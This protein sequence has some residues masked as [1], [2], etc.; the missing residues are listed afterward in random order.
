MQTRFSRFL[1]GFRGYHRAQFLQNLC[2]CQSFA[3]ADRLRTELMDLRRV[4]LGSVNGDE[5]FKWRARCSSDILRGKCTRVEEL[6]NERATSVRDR[7]IAIPVISQRDCPVSMLT[8]SRPNLADARYSG[9]I[10]EAQVE[11]SNGRDGAKGG[12]NF[13]NFSVFGTKANKETATIPKSLSNIF[14]ELETRRS[15]MTVPCELG[16]MSYK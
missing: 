16:L 3:M 5:V 14:V 15:S 10:S 13:P 7:L 11:W 6:E 9:A 1:P 2:V 8:H 12:R 4:L